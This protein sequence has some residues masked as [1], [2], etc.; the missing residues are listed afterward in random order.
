MQRGLILKLGL[1]FINNMEDLVAN[2]A[3]VLIGKRNGEEVT[4]MPL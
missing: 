2:R 4:Y 1:N 3:K